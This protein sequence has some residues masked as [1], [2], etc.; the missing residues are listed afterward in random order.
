E[1]RERDV[2]AIR[3]FEAAVAAISEEMERRVLETSYTLRD[4][5]EGIEQAVTVTRKELDDDDRLVEGDM[6]YVEEMWSSLHAQCS[7]RSTCIKVFREGLERIERLRSEEVGRELRRLVDDMVAIAFRMPDEVERI[8]EEYAAELN[9]VLI[10]NRLAHAELLAKMEK[11]DFVFSVSIRRAWEIRRESWRRLRHGRALGYLRADLTAPNFTNPCE[12]VALFRDFKNGQT[13]RHARR[14][15]LLQDLCSRRP[16]AENE[17]VLETSAVSAIREAYTALHGEEIA[18][19]LGVRDGLTHITKIKQGE[20]EVRREAIRSELHQYGALSAEPDLEACCVQLERVAHNPAYEDFLRKASGLK[21]ELIGLVQGMR[22]PDIIYETPL[23][24]AVERTDLV[25]CGVGLESALDKQGKAGM[26]RAI[27][28]S[29]ERLRKAAKNDIPSAL[30]LLQ[31]QASDL[32]QVPELDSLFVLGLE[33]AVED[34]DRVL[35]TI[36]RRGGNSTSGGGAPSV[37]SRVSRGSRMSK[38]TK[39]DRRHVRRGSTCGSSAGGTRSG[40]S[41]GKQSRGGGWDCEIDIDMIQ[42]RAV[43]RRLGMFASVSDLTDKFKEELR[44]IRTALEQQRACNLAVDAVVVEEANGELDAR[45]SEHSQLLDLSIRAM[46]SHA[47]GLHTCAEQVC[48]FFAAV[49]MELETHES[50]E[51]AIDDAAEARMFEC[52]EDFRL[53]DEDREEAVKA[54]TDRVRMA[55]DEEEL[56]VSFA[57]AISLLDEV[58]E[59]YREYHKIAFTAA[60]VHPFQAT[61]EAVRVRAAIA[62]LLGLR[63]P[64]DTTAT[65]SLSSEI[66][67][68]ENGGDE[69]DTDGGDEGGGTAEEDER[70]EDL[71]SNQAQQEGANEDAEESDTRRYTPPRAEGQEDSMYDVE[72]SPDEIAQTLLEYVPGGSE[73]D[74]TSSTDS[75][76]GD[77]DAEEPRSVETA[78]ESVEVSTAP[79]SGNGSGKAGKSRGKGEKSAG[80]KQANVDPAETTDEVDVASFWKKGFVPLD[81]K[82]MQELECERGKGALQDY[83]DLRDRRFRILTAQEYEDLRIKCE[84]A[85]AARVQ[86]REAAAKKAKKGAKKPK[87]GAAPP[88]PDEVEIDPPSALEIYDGIKSVVEEHSNMRQEERARERERAKL[89]PRDPDGEMVMEEVWMS[90]DDLSSMLHSLRDDLVTRVEARARARQVE[91]TT[92]CAETQEIL[93]EELEERLRK[94]WPRKGRTE[95]GSRQPREGELGAHRQRA[96]RLV[97]E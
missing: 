64:P 33:R 61:E 84:A 52:K 16:G 23:S 3:R 29:V 67:G 93:T 89:V 11:D 95:V 35:G 4:D 48:S 39:G 1:R 6:P 66:V 69:V 68:D 34:I 24:V 79:D 15:A 62:A 46:D 31:R 17:N 47:L 12:R 65:S 37:G 73:E 13:L 54:S 91:T 2:H 28:D 90:V 63:P 27:M 42:V 30:E 76:D 51:V 87:K 56:E 38:G 55:A 45:F 26:R 7:S 18:A 94:H 85:A 20:G 74:E 77:G 57:K 60:T 14:V 72:Q 36:E 80:S 58:E 9:S 25:L 83:L 5:L 43:Q 41:S 81:E 8:A 70:E 75:L 96:R 44:G 32:S 82:Q 21:H 50:T 71:Q 22:S 53:A 97:R 78:G 40:R 86:A 59:S 19:I 92:V 88:P 10:S 49:A